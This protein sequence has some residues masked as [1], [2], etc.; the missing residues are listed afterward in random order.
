MNTRWIVLNILSDFDKNPGDLER[1][2][3]RAINKRIEHRDR[4]F[5]FELVF[6]IVRNRTYIDYCI[7]KFL[8]GEKKL[9]TLRRILQIG[10]YQILFMDRVPD[11]AAVN[12]SVKLAKQ[13]RKSA[14][15]SGV[16]NAVLRNIIKNKHKITLPDSQK[17]LLERLS[18]EFSHPRWMIQR[19]LKNFGLAKTKKIL[20]FNNQ[21]PSIFLRRRIRN[22]SRQQFESDVRTICEPAGGYLNLF[23]KMKKPLDPENIRLLQHG[24]CTVQAPSSGWVVA[25]MD[26]K[27]SDH[28]LDICSAPGG[29]TTLMAE[30]AGDTGTVVACDFKLARLQKVVQTTQLMNLGNVYSLVCDGANPPFTGHFDKLLLDAPCSGTGVLN[31]HPDGRWVRTPEDIG[32]ILQVQRKLLSSAADLIGPDGILVYSTCSLEP[33]ENEKQIEWFLKE[34]PQFR[35]DQSP[36]V[37]PGKFIDNDGFLRITPFEHNMDGMFGVRLIKTS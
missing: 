16:V 1:L 12:E 2:T 30:I 6:G 36:E 28:I 32:Q 29:K 23:Y 10:V 4:R 35:V 5:I 13:N 22:I 34:H 27:K 21:R 9:D 19:W 20:S 31:R 15:A 8:T 7:N 17:D 14:G 33:E 24:Y 11:H 37:I 26:V 25:L 18:V 3:D